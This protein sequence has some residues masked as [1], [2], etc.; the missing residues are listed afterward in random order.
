MAKSGE[1][2]LATVA[3]LLAIVSV[4]TPRAV[5][6]HGNDTIA[7]ASTSDGGGALLALYDFASPVAVTPS[8][9]V[10]GL[11]HEPAD[12]DDVLAAFARGAAPPLATP[13]TE[14]PAPSLAR[15]EWEHIN[16]V[17]ADC[18]GN[19]SAAARRLG[20]HRRS[21][22]RKLQKYPPSQ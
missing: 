11:T 16:R 13:E 7:I 8:L 17:L 4:A 1:K 21:L 10:G 20:L 6:A 2:L 14:L 18:G 9:S 3:S 5:H 22:Q 19:V 12:A 15:A